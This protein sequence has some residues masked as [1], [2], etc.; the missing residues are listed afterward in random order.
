MNGGME[1][2]FGAGN[3]TAAAS[4]GA[5]RA[6]TVAK[7]SGD[8]SPAVEQNGWGR[9]AAAHLLRRAGFGPT[10][11]E[12]DQAVSAGPQQTISELLA[13]PPQLEPLYAELDRFEQHAGRANSI[14]S[15]RAWWL[16]RMIQTPQPLLEKLTLCWHSHFAV[17]AGQVN[18][19]A[20]MQ[21][22]VAT[23]R[24][25]AL[26]TFPELL[27]A[28]MFD[29]ATLASIGAG[30]NRAGH[31]NLHLG[32][33]VLEQY[34]VGPGCYSHEDVRSVARAFTGWRTLRHRT[35]FFAHDHDSGTKRLLG[36][37]GRL[38]AKDVVHILATHPATAEHIAGKFYRWFVA[39][40]GAVPKAAVQGLARRFAQSGFNIA[41]LVETIIRSRQ[42][43]SPAVRWSRVK[44][45]VEFAV[46]IIRASGASVPTAPLGQDLAYIGQALYE[47]P[48][49][50][51][52]RGGRDWTN[53]TTIVGRCNLAYALL[54]DSDRYGGQLNLWQVARS[55]GARDLPEAARF[56]AELF[57]PEAISTELLETLVEK[58]K[59]GGG[60]V[61]DQVRR[62]AYALFCLPQFQLC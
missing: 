45:P 60:G 19:A 17:S 38:D 44:S 56:I 40:S 30:A 37:K 33:R 28:V 2:S 39:E 11:D 53:P 29:A 12:L 61:G 58:A 59:S 57:L 50:N 5:V 35:R 1:T 31:L 22:H 21:Q 49:P 20:L 43:Y 34:T 8:W 16:R 7:Q 46:G 3:F 47:P 26:G 42:F 54:N 25:H 41:K 51:G 15:L 23:L 52:W 24:R 55:R 36:E 6:S 10:A 4:A 13:T 62:F 27:E 32:Q 18:Y 48:A 9:A 14:D